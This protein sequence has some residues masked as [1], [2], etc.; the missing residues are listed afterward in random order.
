[1]AQA[2]IGKYY[3]NLVVLRVA[4]WLSHKEDCKDLVTTLVAMHSCPC[5]QLSV[6]G[7]LATF[8]KRAVGMFTGSRSAAAAGR[9]PLL[10]VALLRLS[11]WQKS[12]LKLKTCTLGMAT[13]VDNLFAIARSPQ[14][15]MGILDDCAQYLNSKWGLKIGSES[16]EYMTCKGYQVPITVHPSWQRRETMR[17]LGHYLDDD[18]GT[19]SCSQHAFAAMTK[20]FF[21]NLKPGLLKSAKAAKLRFLSTCVCTIARGRWSRWPFT[22]TL[23]SRVDALQRKILYS[24]FPLK[25]YSHESLQS[26]YER[27]HRA[28]GHLASSAGRW[29]QLWAAD[30]KNWHAHVDRGHDAH[31]WSPYLLTWKGHQWLSLQRLWHSAVG[32]SRTNTIIAHGKVYRRWEEGLQV[33]QSL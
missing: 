22:H 31:A 16:K 11:H 5:I 6:G 2:D 17:V 7:E 12:G 32:E 4:C 24:L 27:R 18:G 25:P 26:F 10:D 28:A 19:R 20:A 8:K 33:V 9:I 3:D 1:M 23:A 30:L 15:A 14:A 13:F 21:G 29:S